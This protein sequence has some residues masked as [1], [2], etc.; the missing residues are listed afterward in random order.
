M[1]L[2]RKVMANAD[3]NHTELMVDPNLIKNLC[4]IEKNPESA[5]LSP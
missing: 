5:T 1:G 2:S 3:V 4:T